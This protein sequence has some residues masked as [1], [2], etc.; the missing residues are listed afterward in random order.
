M[1]KV[2]IKFGDTR[3]KV[4][5]WEQLQATCRLFNLVLPG[6]EQDYELIY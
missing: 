4:T 3:I 6:C 2:W 5:S 1:F